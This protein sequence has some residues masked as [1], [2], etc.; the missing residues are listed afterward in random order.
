VL[1]SAAA[2]NMP[3]PTPCNPLPLQTLPIPRTHS[4]NLDPPK[5]L[6]PRSSTASSTTSTVITSPSNMSTRGCHPSSPTQ[7]KPPTPSPI[8][9]PTHQIKRTN[10]PNA[11]SA[12]P[13]PWSPNKSWS[14]T[15][16]PTHVAPCPS[17]MT[18]NST[19][20]L[21]ETTQ[22]VSLS[23][24]GADCLVVS[25]TWACR[26]GSK[27]STMPHCIT[28]RGWADLSSGGFGPW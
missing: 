12:S 9:T 15:E 26:L 17:P 24:L 1:P 13:A 14:E 22:K 21:S 16:P 7:K 10:A 18:T 5:T 2:A 25:I 4:T 19:Y 27:A 23:T 11:A 6:H 20:P 3:F 8:I 28:L